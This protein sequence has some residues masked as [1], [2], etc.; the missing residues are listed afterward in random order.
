MSC[1]LVTY[2]IQLALA[3][4]GASVGEAG[5]MPPSYSLL[6]DYFSGPGNTRAMSAYIMG[7]VMSALLAFSVGGWLVDLYGWRITFF[8]AGIPGLVLAVILKLT[9]TEPRARPG[10][11]SAVTERPSAKDVLVTMWRQKSN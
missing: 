10:Y 6:G 8:L 1:G 2:L 7:G 11:L 9:V 5:C 3:G 4:V